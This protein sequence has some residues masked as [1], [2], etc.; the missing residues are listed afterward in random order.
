MPNIPTPTVIAS[1]PVITR[2]RYVR[3]G[4]YVHVHLRQ[5]IGERW[6]CERVECTRPE[7]A[8]EG[9]LREIGQWAAARASERSAELG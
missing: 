6:T 2:T 4:L 5:R 3:I 7:L 1:D 9:E 8:T